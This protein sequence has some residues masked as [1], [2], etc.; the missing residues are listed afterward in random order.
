MAHNLHSCGT[1]TLELWDTGSLAPQNVGSLF[2]S[3]DQTHD[4]HTARQTLNHWTTREAPLPILDIA[5][6]TY[7]SQIPDLSFSLN[8]NPLV[9]ISSLSKSVGLLQL[10]TEILKPHIHIPVLRHGPN[11]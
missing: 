6:C 2:L 8:P 4:L 10:T 3:R 11:N 5:M 7:Q 9:T 1:Q